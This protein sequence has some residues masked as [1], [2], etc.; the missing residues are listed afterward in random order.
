[1]TISISGEIE[2]TFTKILTT[3]NPILETQTETKHQ[4]ARDLRINEFVNTEVLYASDCKAI[5]S[6]FWIPL[7][8][9]FPHL[10]KQLQVRGDGGRWVG[11]SLFRFISF[12]FIFTMKCIISREMIC[13]H[14]IV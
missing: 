7:M 11:V 6:E 14:E 3:T 12:H 8:T 10:M 13:E 1:L 5:V 4:N 2:F 9:S